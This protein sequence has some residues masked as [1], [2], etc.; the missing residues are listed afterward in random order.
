MYDVDASALTGCGDGGFSG[1]S[2]LPL[3]GQSCPT[4]SAWPIAK[5]PTTKALANTKANATNTIFLFIR[6]N[7]KK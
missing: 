3:F 7:L 6:V 4:A 5:F 1:E 2:E